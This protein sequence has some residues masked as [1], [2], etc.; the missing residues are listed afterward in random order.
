MNTSNNPCRLWSPKSTFEHRKNRRKCRVIFSL[1]G[2]I[3]LSILWALGFGVVAIL[4]NQDWQRFI[5]WGPRMGIGVAFI[6]AF[7]AWSIVEM[8]K[9]G[10]R[11]AIAAFLTVLLWTFIIWLPAASGSI[12][13]SIELL[14]WGSIWPLCFWVLFLFL[15]LWPL[16]IGLREVY[17]RRPWWEARE[18]EEFDLLARDRPQLPQDIV[19]RL[20]QA[21][22]SSGAIDTFLEF[23]GSEQ[24][25]E[26]LIKEVETPYPELDSDLQT[27]SALSSRRVRVASK[28][29]WIC[30][31]DEVWLL[32]DGRNRIKVQAQF[33]K[34]MTSSSASFDLAL[35]FRC[36]FDPLLIENPHFR[37]KLA[38]W[39]GKIEE[40]IPGIL[41]NVAQNE[42]TLFFVQ[43]SLEEALSDVSVITFRETLLTTFS[44]LRSNFGATVLG[45][46][47]RCTPINISPRIQE[48]G[49]KQKTASALAEFETR[50]VERWIDELLHRR[51][52]PFSEL[53]RLLLLDNSPNPFLFSSGSFFDLPPE[54]KV[55]QIIAQAFVPHS[56]EMR[57]QIKQNLQ[58]ALDSGPIVLENQSP[59]PDDDDEEKILV[60]PPSRP[61]RLSHMFRKKD[62][63]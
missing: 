7:A 39:E 25:R 58:H 37:S 26:K 2:A 49:E 43:R 34:I 20:E 36:K 12:N 59:Q 16:E 10:L 61:K 13:Y 41:K 27:L 54:Q 3:A 52:I 23:Q 1:Y 31:L 53:A 50:K 19:E 40:V 63:E 4:V 6:S 48:A 32:W 42:A 30:P 57:L 38:D 24:A 18:E 9:S 56:E 21:G 22:V 28:F 35:D 8:N 62:D 33:E 47:M 11:L 15:P 14:L 29:K 60:E 17:Y 55:H 51:G 45:W 46:S 44:N 5:S